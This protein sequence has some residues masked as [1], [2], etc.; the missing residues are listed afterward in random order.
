MIGG[1]GALDG[2]GLSAHHL[3]ALAIYSLL[4]TSRALFV[5]CMIR[6]LHKSY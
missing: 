4:G 5:Y 3:S 1:G 6:Y 2:H